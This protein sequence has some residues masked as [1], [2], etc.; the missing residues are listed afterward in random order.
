MGAEDSLAFVPFSSSA[1]SPS[2]KPP[3]AMSA[4][5]KQEATRFVN[6]LTADGVAVPNV[7]D[8]LQTAVDL[9]RSIRVPRRTAAIFLMTPGNVQSG[10]AREVDVQGLPVFT[11]GFGDA[12]KMEL[13]KDIAYMSYGG[14]YQNVPNPATENLMLPNVGRTL[15]IVR[16]ISVLNVSVNLRPKG[17]AKIQQVYA[18]DTNNT[19]RYT[20]RSRPTMDGSMTAEFGDLART[21]RRSI[22]V[23]IQLPA[24][25]ADQNPN[26]FLDIDCTYRPAKTRRIETDRAWVNMARSRGAGARLR[27]APTE[28]FQAEVARR[29]HVLRLSK[30]KSLADGKR[31][32]DGAMDELMAE[33]GRALQQSGHAMGANMHHAL[34]LELE[35]LRRLLRS[36]EVYSSRGRAYMLAAILSHDRQRF[37]ARGGDQD[38][39]IFV[40]PR[41]RKY[42]E[43]AHEFHKNPNAPI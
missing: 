4:S 18:A 43:H 6:G 34:S 26:K 27:A 35:Q 23:D 22:F 40:L 36:H 41:M 8:G 42:A 24:V 38:V 33:A 3:K 19:S 32:N 30:M 21:E 7:R 11:F 28:D 20:G 13:L 12:L 29:D 25:A 5:A 2:S 16:D 9:L 10:E 39:M 15:A 17:G 31:F 14:T 37:A 1:G